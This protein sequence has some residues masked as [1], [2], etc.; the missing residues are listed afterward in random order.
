MNLSVIIVDDKPLAV[1][2]LESYLQKI[3]FATLA[4]SFTN[5]LEALA[6]IE[7]N[8]PDIVL[9]DIQMPEITGVQ[10][11]R[12]A[13]SHS[14][15]ILTTAYAEYAVEGFDLEAVDYLLKPV[16]FDRFYLAMQKAKNLFAAV[17]EM[18]VQREVQSAKDFMF[19]RTDRKIRKINYAD[20]LFIEARQNYIEIHTPQEKMMALQTM[21]QA[22]DTLP[23]TGF[24]RVHKSF[25]VNIAAIDGIEQ[26]I[27]SMGNARI[28]VGEAYRT[29]FYRTI[30][31]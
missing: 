22:M 15:Y 29:E 18:P 6:F 27:I 17:P 26:H 28:P 9:L 11:M 1:E 24:M 12:M 25:I 7:Q 23:V 16:S 10:L 2:I 30:G 19:I 21:K 14:R 31:V 20:I 8:R 4:G 13:G 3:S 5:P